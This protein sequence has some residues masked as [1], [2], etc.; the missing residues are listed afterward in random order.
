MALKA[1]IFKADLSIADM[2]RHYY[3]DHA[4]TLARHPSETDERMMV[5]L[6]AFT[7]HAGE[8]LTFAKGPNVD[9]EPALWLRD[10][11]GTI[12]SWIDVGLP[13]E[14]RIRKA[15]GRA[16]QVIIYT[17]G[18]RSADLWWE[19]SSSKLEVINNLTVI[20]LA[21]SATLA[22]AKLAQRTMRLQCTVQEG[23][24]WLADA[25]N[26]VQVDLAILKAPALSRR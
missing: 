20:N 24:V 15:C 2:D 22:L 7:L 23:Q 1:T 17:Y 18:G 13:D 10:L 8:S 25:D 3:H 11:S 26:S 19:Q 12:Q 5:R 21:Q 16:R 4:L 9:D 6:L 14:K